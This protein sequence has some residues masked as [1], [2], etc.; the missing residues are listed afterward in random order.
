MMHIPRLRFTIYDL[1]QKIL[2]QMKDNKKNS[3]LIYNFKIINEHN[4]CVL[5]QNLTSKN[6]LLNNMR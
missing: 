5:Y 2:T 4:Y 6:S 1:L 3:Y